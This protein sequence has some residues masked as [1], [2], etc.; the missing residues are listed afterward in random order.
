MCTLFSFVSCNSCKCVLCLN[1][2]WLKRLCYNK[3]TKIQKGEDGT[4]VLLQRKRWYNNPHTLDMALQSLI[5]KN[6]CILLKG[7]DTKTHKGATSQNFLCTFAKCYPKVI[8]ESEML[9][10][11]VSCDAPLH[12]I[13]PVEFD[14]SFIRCLLQV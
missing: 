9:L 3:H 1:S 11:V 4:E 12:L 5:I 2:S 7:G 10:I 8:T 14:P 6:N 13:L